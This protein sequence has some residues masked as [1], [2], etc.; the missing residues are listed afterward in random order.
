MKQFAQSLSKYT[1]IS[2]KQITEAMEAI[3]KDTLQEI[4]DEFYSKHTIHSDEDGIWVDA[5][6]FFDWL[7]DNYRLE[8]K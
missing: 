2:A 4:E 8:K 5:G 1:G 3:Q 7:A 6:E